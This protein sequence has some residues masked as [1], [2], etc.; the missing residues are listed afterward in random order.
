[1]MDQLII[2]AVEAAFQSRLSLDAGAVLI[3][4]IDGLEAGL[5]ERAERIARHRHA[6]PAR[7]R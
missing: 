2:R 4:E 6:R 1:M 3:I 5:D 7:P